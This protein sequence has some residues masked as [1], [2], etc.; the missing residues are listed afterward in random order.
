M[1]MVLRISKNNIHYRIKIFII[2]QTA[3]YGGYFIV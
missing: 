3:R 2:T 1:L